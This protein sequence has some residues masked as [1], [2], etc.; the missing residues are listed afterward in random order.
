MAHSRTAMCW[1]TVISVSVSS[2]FDNGVIARYAADS[3][4]RASP[5]GW[6][7]AAS[8]M[9]STGNAALISTSR[10]TTI[11]HHGIRRRYQATRTGGT[12][13]DAVWCADLV[14]WEVERGNAI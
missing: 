8:R 6:R 14:G 12:A 2:T 13:D 4:R 1:A 3:S 5:S 10:V 7:V 11:A 9:A